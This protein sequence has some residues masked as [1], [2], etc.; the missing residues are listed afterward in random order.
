MASI[1]AVSMGATL[2]EKHITLD[3]NLPGPDHLASLDPIEFKQMISEIRNIK[4]MMGSSKKIPT[5]N[6]IRNKSVARKS[7]FA[8]KKIKKGCHLTILS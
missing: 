3:K 5:A 8:S 7:I 4:I 1:I 6:E 2:I